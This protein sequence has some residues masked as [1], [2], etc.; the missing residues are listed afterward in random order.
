MTDSTN[1][2]L[3]EQVAQRIDPGGKL[4]RSWPLTGGVSA[5]VTALEIERADGH[6]QKMILRRHG[7]IDLQHNPQIA[8]DEFALLQILRS[9]A[10]P[11]PA[12][13][14]LDESGTIF[15][16]PY[17]VMEFIDGE[18]NF[19]PANL[20]T[21]IRQVAAVLEQIHHIHSGG[22]SLSF[23]PRL[24]DRVAEKLKNPPAV[25]DDSLD[26]GRIREMLL[27]HWP[28]AATNASTLLHGDFWPGN[29][30][31]KDG[32]LRAVIDW[33]D[34]LIGDPLA[35]LANARLEILFAFGSEAMQDFTR[36]YQHC[37]TA[38]PALDF[39]NLSFWDLWAA[40]RPAGK[41][42]TWRLDPAV[43]ARMRQRH[44]GFIQQAFEKLS[45]QAGG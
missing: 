15:P 10:L 1:N 43:E 26:E 23:L 6:I 39:G 21:Y 41:L 42:G 45:P 5:Q 33:E 30:L 9:S 14:H 4:L 19:A 16:T 44:Q 35:D 20:P 22:L 37:R 3:F 29:I 25:L 8:A 38:I 27:A 34:A 11:V 17:L 7:A 36:E 28:L 12:P 40:L 2:D 18:T 24:V 31:C 32:Q 13:Y